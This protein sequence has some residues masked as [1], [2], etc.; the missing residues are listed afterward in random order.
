MCPV[1]RRIIKVHDPAFMPF[2]FLWQSVSQE[3]ATKVF[4]I[5]FFTAS[6]IS[7]LLRG[8]FGNTT[9]STWIIALQARVIY[10]KH[11]FFWEHFIKFS[12]CCL[13]KNFLK[14]DFRNFVVSQHLR[15]HVT[16]WVEPQLNQ[17]FL[18]L[19]SLYFVEKEF[20][21][22][23][24]KFEAL[25]K[26]TFN[27][28]KT[29]PEIVPMISSKFDKNPMFRR[30]I[31]NWKIKRQPKV[32]KFNKQWYLLIIVECLTFFS[33]SPLSILW[34]SCSLYKLGSIYFA[35]HFGWCVDLNDDLF[36]GKFP[37]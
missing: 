28:C 2:Q 20:F 19:M 11:F 33:L 25:P 23:F 18:L 21:K 4:Q 14:L 3:N 30:N 5:N 22:Y 9:F 24:L 31:Q 17:S 34:I 29:F 8:L 15:N 35:L 6:S 16:N 7:K 12:F 26:N 1:S 13:R 37:G 36:A 27:P 10:S 32:K